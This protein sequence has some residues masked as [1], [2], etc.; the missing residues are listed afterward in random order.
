VLLLL[1]FS[2]LKLLETRTHRDAAAAAFLGYF[3]IV[4]NFLYTQSIPTAAAMGAA[5]FGITAT[6]VGLSAPYRAPRANLGT[7]SLL[8]AHAAPAALVLFL[9]FPRVQGPL[10][11]LPQDAYTAMTGLSDTM[12]PGHISRLALSDQIAFRAEFQGESPLHVLRY[13]RG[14][15][16]WDFDGRSW[17][18]GALLPSD[19]APPRFGRVTYRYSVLLEPH[20]RN[21]LFA[22]E[23]AASVPPDAR[24]SV[25]G[26]LLARL[27]VRACA[28]RS[29]RPLAW[30]YVPTSA[31][32]C[33]A[34]RCGCRRAPTPGRARS[35]RNGAPARRA[36]SSC[37][38]A[39]SPSCARAAICTR[40]SRRCSGPIRWTN[41]CSARERASASISPRRSCS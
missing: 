18:V 4:T 27:P 3:L 24:Y 17:S 35:R 31:R 38:R 1:L 30:R 34:A 32:S 5:L 7:T 29:C 39:P 23:T 10:W 19:E 11:G 41:F 9:L 40:S 20:N 21:W 33:C 28:T 36:T 2:G 16:M 6:L 37:S 13:W 26:Q 14:P 25:D 15:V 22:L 8:L 12:T